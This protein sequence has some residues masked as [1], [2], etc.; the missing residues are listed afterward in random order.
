MHAG[1]QEFDSLILHIAIYKIAQF[2]D[3]I[4]DEIV[5]TIINRRSL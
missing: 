2:I 4:E 5:I 3:I 1:G